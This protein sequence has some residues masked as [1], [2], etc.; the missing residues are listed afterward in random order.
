MKRLTLALFSLLIVVLCGISVVAQRRTAT[1]PVAR[2][3][4]IV[5]KEFYTW[6]IHADFHDIDPFKGKARVTLKKYVTARFIREM[7]KNEKLVAESGLESGEAFDADYF[8]QTQDP[9]PDKD[10]D[11]KETDWLKSMSVSKVAVRGS[12]ATAIVTFLGGYPKVKVSLIK[13]GAV[14]KI[15]NVKDARE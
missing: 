3:P 10:S 12:T 7:D 5:L 4:E 6:Y 11:L 8:L 9:L 2:S 13:E 14:W 15:N 1:P